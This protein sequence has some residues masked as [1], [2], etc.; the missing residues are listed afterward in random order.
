MQKTVFLCK[1]SLFQ[2]PKFIAAHEE[3][4]LV[5]SAILLYFPKLQSSPGR[6]DENTCAVGSFSLLTNSKM[7]Q[8]TFWSVPTIF[9]VLRWTVSFDSSNGILL[10]S[11]AF[12]THLKHNQEPKINGH[13]D[14]EHQSRPGEG[15]GRVELQTSVAWAV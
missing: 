14:D 12:W 1:S 15:R 6:K 13:T 5:A 8:E 2:K 11:A 7:H 10:V 4:H 9:S 3:S